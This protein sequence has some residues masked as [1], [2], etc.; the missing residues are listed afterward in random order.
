LIAKLQNYRKLQC[1]ESHERNPDKAFNPG[2]ILSYRV[3]HD[4]RQTHLY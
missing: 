3:L 1:I 4:V 2:F